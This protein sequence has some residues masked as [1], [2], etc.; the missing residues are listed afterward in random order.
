MF[1][2]IS[3][4]LKTRA[5]IGDPEKDFR[6]EDNS[7]GAGPF[8]KFW[9]VAQLGAQPTTQELAALDVDAGFAAFKTSLVN[10]AARPGASLAALRRFALLKTV[11]L[12]S[13]AGTLARP[14]TQKINIA[15]IGIKHL[16]RIQLNSEIENMTA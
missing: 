2:K 8:I 6:L 15:V 13:D 7:D 16:I 3:Y 4:I 10:I 1:N 14:N 5:K 9:D 12:E 11:L